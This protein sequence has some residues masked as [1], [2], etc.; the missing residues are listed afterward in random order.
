VSRPLCIIDGSNLARRAYHAGGSLGVIHAAA[1]VRALYG[2]NIEV[3]AAWDGPPPTWR[4]RLWPAYKAHRERHPEALAA[5]RQEYKE[6]RAQGIVG[7]MARDGEAD[8]AAATLAHRARGA[9]RPVVVVSSDKDWG[10]LMAIGCEW[11]APVAGGALEKRTE[12]WFIDRYGCGPE[13]WPDYVGLAGD[14]T[15]GIPGVRGIGP[16]K[17]AALL[18]KFGSLEGALNGCKLEG[19][20]R[21]LAYTS[22]SLAGLDASSDIDWRD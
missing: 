16:K 1:K 21:Q 4:H 19:E 9:G 6:A 14:S 2:E 17:A 20:V 7:I 13:D 15:D 8:D 10:Q 12:D 22:C 5:V 18:A 11:L 3:V